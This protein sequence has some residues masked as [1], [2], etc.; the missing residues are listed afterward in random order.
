MTAPLS[1]RRLLGLAA[2]AGTTIV[3]GCTDVAAPDAA[4]VISSADPAHSADPAKEAPAAPTPSTTTPASAV[5]ANELGM[6]PVLMHHRLATS[7]SG[8]YDMTPAF[9]RAELERLHAEGY[10]PIRTLDLVRRDFSRVPAGRTPVVLTFDDST[11][12][13]FALDAAGRV[14]PDTAVGIMLAFEERHPDFPA[15]GSFYLNRSPFGLSGSAAVQALRRLHALGCELGNHTWSHPNLRQI[16]AGKVQ[17]EF[18]RL[19]ASVEEAVPGVAPRTMALPLGIHPR[20]RRLMA[21][22]GQGGT[23]YRNEGVLLVGAGPCPSPFHRDFEPMAIARIRCSSHQGG[24]G[25]LLMDYWLDR[26]AARP[27]LKFV[28]SGNAGHVTA[29]R[30]EAAAIAPAFR[31]R[32]LWYDPR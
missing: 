17:E 2:A 8:E 23:A 28:A 31:S 29:P 22:G 26:F 32:A 25:N 30:R 3:A 6:I 18:G 15:V 1:R 14:V 20:D 27:D 21:R 12:G 5:K 19:S 4:P 24:K 9:F 16:D 11:P 13:Q 7:V 10:F